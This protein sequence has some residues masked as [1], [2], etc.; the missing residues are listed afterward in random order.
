VRTLLPS[1]TSVK[2]VTYSTAGTE[3]FAVWDLWQRG[4]QAVDVVGRRACVTAQELPAVLADATE[5]H[6]MV[7]LLFWVPPDFF[8]NLLTLRIV[9]LSF[10]L[11]PLLLLQ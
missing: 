1:L 4:V 11:D 3:P 2:R 5:F 7:I 8:Q 9:L 10:P 6:V